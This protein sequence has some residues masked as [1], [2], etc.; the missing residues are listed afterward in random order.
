MLN[1][2]FL[3]PRRLRL[4]VVAYLRGLLPPYY[5]NRHRSQIREELVLKALSDELDAS[6]MVHSMFIDSIFWNDGQN[7][8]RVY[9]EMYDKIEEIRQLNELTPDAL[10]KTKRANDIDNLEKLYMILKDT[11]V[12]EKLSKKIAKNREAEFKKKYDF[13]IV[14]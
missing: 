7:R 11:G 13:G 2:K 1:G 12:L 8:A 3:E 14:E 10:V 5:E 9:D 4:Y 6:S